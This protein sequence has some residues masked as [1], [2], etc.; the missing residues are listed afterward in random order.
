MYIHVLYIRSAGIAFVCPSKANLSWASLMDGAMADFIIM[1]WWSMT[2][3][4]K[5]VEWKGMWYIP[6]PLIDL[7]HFARLL[8]SSYFGQVMKLCRSKWWAASEI[9]LVAASCSLTSLV[10]SWHQFRLVPVIQLMPIGCAND[11]AGLANLA[12]GCFMT[13]NICLV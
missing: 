5:M 3:L 13:S 7:K 10:V 12:E 1:K 11:D 8:D 6:T 4:W 2:A 9:A